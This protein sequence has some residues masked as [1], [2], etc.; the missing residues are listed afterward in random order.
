MHY[1]LSH[2]IT[3]YKRYAFIYIKPKPNEILK[4]NWNSF[5]YGDNLYVYVLS[6]FSLI[7]YLFYIWC[8]HNDKKLCCGD[9][10]YDNNANHLKV[11]KLHT[12]Q[13]AEIIY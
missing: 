2:N 11:I 12:K 4:L 10:N 3:Y 9:I 1:W 13:R 6:G 8:L 5:A 7:F